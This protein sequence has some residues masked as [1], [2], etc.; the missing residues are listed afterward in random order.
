[1][2]LAADE[3]FRLVA[4]SR[5][6]FC[7]G[8]ARQTT[9]TYIEAFPGNVRDRGPVRSDGKQFLLYHGPAVRVHPS[10]TA[11]RRLTL[12]CYGANRLI[13]QY[14]H[15]LRTSVERR[16]HPL[17]VRP[18]H[19]RCLQAGRV[20]CSPHVVGWSCSGQSH[21]RAEHL[22]ATRARDTISPLPV[23]AGAHPAYHKLFRLSAASYDRR[24][25]VEQRRTGLCARRSVCVLLTDKP[26]ENYC[27]CSVP[28]RFPG[29]RGRLSR[30]A[31]AAC[32]T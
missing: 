5:R 2:R 13:G 28:S 7:T 6:I 31:Y 25:C 12:S 20:R 4:R 30:D 15:L 10:R 26:Q 18:Q 16:L 27:P 24:F 19:P 9:G 8:K 17:F 21:P 1:M 29:G 22:G 3:N 14:G 11:K 23:P 32:F